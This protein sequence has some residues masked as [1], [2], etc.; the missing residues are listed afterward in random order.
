[1][2]QSGPRLMIKDK[3]GLRRLIVFVALVILATLLYFVSDV[4]EQLRSLATANSD[5]VQWTLSQAEVEA[6]ALE[7]EAARQHFAENPD[8]DAVRLRF[9][10]FYSRYATL[11]DSPIYAELREDERVAAALV[12]LGG[13]FQETIPIIDGGD[14][15]LRAQ[16]DELAREARAAQGLLRETAIA[17]IEIFSRLSDERR[18]SVSRTLL[19]IALLTLALLVLLLAMIVLLVRMVQRIEASANDLRQMSDRMKTIVST[20]LD[21]IVVTD[22][23][24]RIIEYN[25]AAERTFGYSRDTV[26]GAD[27]GPLMVPE[28]MQKMHRNG[29][30]R[31]REGGEASVIGKGIVQLEARNSKGEI[32]PVDLALAAAKGPEGDIIVGFIR[33]ISDRVKAENTLRD[34]RD[35]AVAGEKSKADL[36]A[37]MSHEMRTPLNGILGTLDL[38]DPA[39][40][41][42]PHRRYLR[43]IRNSGKTLLAH[44]NDVL[45][46]S[47]LDVGK[48]SMKQSRFDLVLLLEEIVEGQA[49]QALDGTN[50]LRLTPP[51]PAL[52]EVYGDR[53]RIRQILLNLVGNALKFTRNGVVTVEADCNEGLDAVEI[54]VTDTGIGI[55][56]ADVERIFDDFV[57][58]DASYGRATGGT[59]LGLA[60]SQRLAKLMNGELGAES[61][62]GEGSVFWLRLPLSLPA[63]SA[64]APKDLAVADTPPDQEETRLAPMEILVV[65]DNPTNRIVAREMLERDGHRVFE[66]HDGHEGVLA[67]QTRAFDAILM[68]ISMPGMDGI[69]ATRQIR[70]RGG[71]AADVPIIATTAHAM[72]EEIAAFQA[73]GIC[74]VMI[75]PL[76]FA[77]LRQTL[78]TTLARDASA[79]AVPGAQE[80]DSPLLDAEVL[81]Q[82][83]EMVP[84]DMLRNIYADLVTEM[85]SFI[86]ALTT[87][88]EDTDRSSLASE[89]HR[90]AGS[91]AVFGAQDLNVCLRNLQDTVPDA[92][93][94]TLAELAQELHLSWSRTKTALRNS[95]AAFLESSD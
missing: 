51:S 29:M 48:M 33:D 30:Q 87:L 63:E 20:S 91:A 94:A 69:E 66:A 15:A 85:N 83:V 46:I 50:Q 44:V 67:A 25:E 89:A 74:D 77:S 27:M 11:R 41:D 8:L 49:G 72:P 90:M 95:P 7:T 82:L 13:F 12:D 54:R 43:I 58:V 42:A 56:E 5:N 65:E 26:I 19:D 28:H 18:A 9:D 31:Y 3:A 36:L 4:R 24:G 62:P 35:R 79:G 61:E 1:M 64:D 57:T 45:E 68:D 39:T 53:N 92:S 55:A 21:A 76:S 22:M 23:D 37:V 71:A 80:E 81:E 93:D 59:G 6:K 70:A 38:F 40:L 73:A 17:G 86:A 78:S 10:I 52:H 32:F 34:A 75:K 47:R 16:L 2:K 60:I 88:S 14:S 84:E